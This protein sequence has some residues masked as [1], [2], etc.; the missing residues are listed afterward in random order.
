MAQACDRS[1]AGIEQTMMGTGSTYGGSWFGTMMD[2]SGGWILP[3]LALLVLVGVVVLVV[4]TI[5]RR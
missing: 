5:R 3:V 2:G 1:P 4:W